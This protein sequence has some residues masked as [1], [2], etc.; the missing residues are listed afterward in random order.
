MDCSL[1]GSSVRGILQ[2][3]NTGMGCHFLLQGIFL[4]HELNLGLLCLLCQQ[5][6]SLP[7][8]TAH[9]LGLRR[10]KNHLS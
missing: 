1:P 8:H 4:I 5:V 9:I 2:G 3:E 7:L 6:G 10:D